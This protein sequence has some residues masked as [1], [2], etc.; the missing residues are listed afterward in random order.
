MSVHVLDQAIIKS[1]EPLFEEA[2]RNGL[3][4]FHHSVDGEET[5]MSP[6]YLRLEQSRGRFILAPEH[7]ELRNPTGYMKRLIA[8]ASALV[9]EYNEMA[10]R[11]KLDET[12][13]LVT[14]RAPPSQRDD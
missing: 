3:W 5:W 12:L 1:L 10:A 11:L 8:S 6:Q 4:F 9:T 14:H 7:W 2:E 13:E